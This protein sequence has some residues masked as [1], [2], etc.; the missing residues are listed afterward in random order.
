ME[1]RSNF[2]NQL[3]YLKDDLLNLLKD[4][5]NEHQTSLTAIQQHNYEQS[6]KI[7]EQDAE[8]RSTAEALTKTALWRLISQQPVASD[9]RK[10]IGYIFIIRDLERISNYAKNIS[11]FNIKY[12]PETIV[13]KDITELMTVANVMM[14]M[15]YK[16]I[17]NE[18]SQL[19]FEI[20]K[21]DQLIDKLYPKAMVLIRLNLANTNDNEIIHQYTSAVQQ[22]KY[23]ERLGDH[24]VNICETIHYII[25]GKFINLSVGEQWKAEHQQKQLSQITSKKK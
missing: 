14:E 24:L 16:N 17:E 21:K 3:N 19:Y 1:L 15:L 4:V 6:Q 8:I 22:L 13:V 20:A 9:L 25:T 7:L 12:K 11:V 5:Y 10:I 23:I 18:E 2:Q